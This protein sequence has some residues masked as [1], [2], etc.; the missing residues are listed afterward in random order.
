MNNTSNGSL[1]CKRWLCA[2][3]AAALLL[4]AVSALAENAS[5]YTC[6]PNGGSYVNLQLSP[7]YSGII[8]DR[9]PVSTLLEIHGTCGAWR[10]VSVQGE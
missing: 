6:N 2:L 9:I 4:S 3:V 7:S 1:T 8:A 5:G 10:L